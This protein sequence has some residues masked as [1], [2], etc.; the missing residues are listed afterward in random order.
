M[1]AAGGVVGRRV[2]APVFVPPG[3]IAPIATGP[4]PVLVTVAG[5][6]G[7]APASVSGWPTGGVAGGGDSAVWVPVPV[8]VT[9]NGVWVPAG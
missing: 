9:S 6:A 4:V 3:V 7:A 2:H 8:S 5:C 1:R